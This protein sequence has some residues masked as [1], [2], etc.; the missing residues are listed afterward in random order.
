MPQPVQDH[1]HK[2]A[3]IIPAYKMPILLIHFK[4]SDRSVD[5]LLHHTLCGM[6]Q[7]IGK[8]IPL[9][10]TVQMYH[11]FFVLLNCIDKDFHTVAD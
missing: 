7:I 1:S 4:V 9:D 3:F 8:Y 5:Q 11:G 2:Y 6:I 10:R